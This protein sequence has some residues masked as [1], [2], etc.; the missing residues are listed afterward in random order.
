MDVAKYSTP[1][2]KGNWALITAVAAAVA[3]S[4]PVERLWQFA[5]LFARV[6]FLYFKTGTRG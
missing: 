4:V 1:I 3:F 2:R 5:V 6:V